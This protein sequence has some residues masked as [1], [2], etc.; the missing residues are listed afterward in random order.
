MSDSDPF[1]Y[2]VKFKDMRIKPPK[3]EASRARAQKTR[4]CDHKD[5]DLEGTHPAPKPGGKGQ[6]HFCQQ[7]AAEYN[8]RFNFFEGMS[9]A[10]AAA[11]TRAER[12]GHKRTWRFGTGPMAGQ[13]GAEKLDPRRW[14]GRRFF[15]VDDVAGGE[16]ASSNRRS[17]LQLRAL[18]ELDLE[19]DA[20]PTEIR[21]RYAEYVR[22]FHPDSNKGDR[23]SEHK[24]QRVLRAGK[25]LKA[26]GLMKG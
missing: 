2:R 16:A 18:K 12:F 7:H 21:A 8:R 26:A 6:H 11:F 17:G 20:S 4:V 13:K 22:R 1:S 3:D 14:A 23:S 19:G 10:E 24:L 25:L 9:Q 5:C 15:D